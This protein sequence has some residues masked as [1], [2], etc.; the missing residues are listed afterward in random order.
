MTSII[1]ELATRAHCYKVDWWDHVLRMSP[2][3]ISKECGLTEDAMLKFGT[4]R[5]PKLGK[6]DDKD[7][8]PS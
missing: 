5:N 3:R 6:A 1:E 8:M 2:N 4:V 7:N